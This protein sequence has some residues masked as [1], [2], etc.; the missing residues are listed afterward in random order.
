MAARE[1]ALARIAAI[2]RALGTPFWFSHESAALVWGC[3]LW[4]P[5][6]ETHVIQTIRPGRGGDPSLA[7]HL[8]SLTPA[9][10]Q[11][12]RGVPIT[13]LDRTVADCLRQLPPLDALVIADG[14][15]RL[16]ADRAAIATRLEALA[17]QRGVI[18]A[19]AVLDYADDGA[20]S[21]WETFVRYVLVRFGLPRPELQV[22]IRTR[23]G[24]F[25]S[26]LGWTEWKQLIE[27]DGFAK[28]AG[29]PD[30]ARAM[31]E[32]KRRQ[33]AIEEEGWGVLRVTAPDLSRQHDLIR[34]VCRRLPPVV[35]ANLTPIRALQPRE[36]R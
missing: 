11:E 24:W 2:S 25:W 3:P 16:G 18:G 26:D 8:M 6:T 13:S 21:P 23:L 4:T 35:V 15:L 28:Y 12:F 19:R 34:R 14:A 17:G 27:L 33:E 7:R 36:P 1:L 20:E 10:R 31:F 22:P 29:G 32:E 30:P 5:P 9:D